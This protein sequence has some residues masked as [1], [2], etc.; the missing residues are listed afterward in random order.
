MTIVQRVLEPRSRD[1]GDFSVRRLLPAPQLQTVGPF[2]FFD[3]MGPADFGPGQ[4]VNVRPHP[5]IGLATVTYLFEGAFMHRDSLGTAQLIRPGDVNWM[6][7]GRGIVHSERT[8]DEVR[9]AAGHTRA[10]GIQTWVALPRAHEEI[11][12]SF[13]HHAAASLPRLCVDGAQLTVIAGTA[14]GRRSP[15]EVLSPTLYVDA[16]FTDAG[17]R[18]TLDDE[19]E[20]RAVYVAQGTVDV[21]GAS[22]HEGQLLLLDADAGSVTVTAREAGTRVMLAGGAPLDGARHIWW[23]FV[24]SSPQRIEAAKRQWRDQR[25]PPVPGDPERIPL[26]DESLP[27]TPP[28]PAAPPLS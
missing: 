10:H 19:H 14:F 13:A 9:D 27:G 8:P 16:L 21:G 6:I 4:G 17:A 26:P 11:A 22:Y 2:I 24:S 18:C 5:H 3:H 15:V 20:Q 28:A 23:N 1:L 12:P 25:F 7:A